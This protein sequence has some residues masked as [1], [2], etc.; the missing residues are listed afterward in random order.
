MP[1]LSPKVPHRDIHSFPTR[2]SSDLDLPERPPPWAPK[3]PLAGFE[4][5]FKLL[6]SVVHPPCHVQS[7]GLAAIGFS[8]HT[9]VRFVIARIQ[10]V[11][12]IGLNP[13]ALAALRILPQD[14]LAGVVLVH[15]T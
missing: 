13:V 6:G 4:L 2:R 9:A 12:A 8:V 15:A 1:P 10:I 7:T 5:R 14:N 3:T 11:S